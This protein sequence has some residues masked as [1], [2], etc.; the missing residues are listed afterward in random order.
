MSGTLGHRLRFVPIVVLLGVAFWFR[1]TRLSS[2]PG[3]SGD[4]AWWGIQALAWSSGKPYETHTTSGNPIDMFFLVPV[5]FVHMIAPP[6]FLLLRV[7]PT[8][9]NLLALP[10][11]FW[12][13]R[14]LYDSETAWLYIVTLALLPTAV[15]HSRI[16]QDPSQSIFWTGIFI[17]ICLVGFK[18]CARAWRYLAAG[19]AIFPIVLWTHPTNVFAA[20]FLLLPAFAAIERFL[21]ASSTRRAGVA[22][23]AVAIAALAAA[24]VMPVL[25]QLPLSSQYLEQPW[26]STALARASDGKQWLEFAVNNARLFNGVTIYHYFSGATAAT[27]PHDAGFLV[28]MMLTAGGFVMMPA[29]RRSPLDYGL[30]AA[31]A[32]MW[33]GFYLFAGPAALRPHFERWGLCL[34]VPGLLI[35]SRGL[36]AWL[37]IPRMQW[38]T[39]VTA[40]ALLAALAGS[41]YVNYFEQFTTT[42]G[43]SHLTYVTASVEPKQQAF[44][45]ILA[46]SPGPGSVAVGSTQWWLYRPLAYL[47]T[48][49]PN[50][51]V[52]VA[53]DV[54]RQP[55][56]AEAVERGRL[57]FVE[58]SDTPELATARRWVEQHGLREET[59]L[60]R[61]ASGRAIVEVLQVSRP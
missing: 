61:D 19:A 3:I 31:C 44:D 32:M 15:A 56:Y 18:D 47:A 10:L 37:S 48:P 28:V 13:V 34:I 6:S 35:I 30:I 57:F 25:E 23:V 4:E 17:F 2:V 45:H 41:F 26:L 53:N 59:T 40:P 5:A 36:G 52:T 46:L 33:I 27:L 58:F 21:P 12:F 49:H 9:V 20:P 24:G 8:V 39:T 55:G 11:G 22:L 7:V 38:V 42:G 60:V 50:V 54:T 1:L 51:T 43:R 16:C 14:R 29:A